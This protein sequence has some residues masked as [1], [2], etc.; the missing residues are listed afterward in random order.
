[1]TMTAIRVSEAIDEA[2]D[3]VR[4]AWREAWAPMALTSVGWMLIVVGA[5]AQIDF[6]AADLLERI[7]WALQIFN[8]PLLGA[9][10]RLGVGG[11]AYRGLGPAGLQLGGVEWRVLVVNAVLGVFCL[12]ACLPLLFLSGLFFFLLHRLGGITLGPIGHWSWWFLL[13]SLFWV[14]LIGWL[15]YMC[16][17]L[18]LATAQSV[19]HRRILPITGWPST[20]G[21]GRVI[22]ASF[23]L[24]K[25][26]AAI[27][28]L[29]LWAFGWIEPSEAPIGLHGPWPLPE[30]IGA[31]AVAGLILSVV[32][33]PLSVGLLI[34]FYDV[35]APLDADRVSDVGPGLDNVSSAETPVPEEPLIAPELPDPPFSTV[36]YFPHTGRFSRIAA[37]W[38]AHEPVPEPYGHLVEADSDPVADGAP[39]A[40]AQEDYPRSIVE[41]SPHTGRFSRLFAPWLADDH[42]SHENAQA[43]AADTEAGR[44]PEPDS[45]RPLALDAAEEAEHA[46]P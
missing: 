11:R 16:A 40:D 12:F 42:P 20:E 2:V 19:E 24:T 3:F 18:G 36:E 21:Q 14:A 27:V 10:Y 13:S 1:M 35:L 39:E 15:I 9:L 45:P 25:A 44:T 37:P 23:I 17:R 34:F 26:P 30:A 6:Q 33:A 29:A 5:R 31:G 41:Y 43:F 46:K 7:G 32:E 38:L 22:A 28:I 8:L 4:G